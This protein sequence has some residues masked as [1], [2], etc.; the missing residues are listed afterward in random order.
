MANVYSSDGIV[1]IRFDYHSRVCMLDCNYY[2]DGVYVL[3]WSIYNV[4]DTNVMAHKDVMMSRYATM[5]V[6]VSIDKHKRA[7]REYICSSDEDMPCVAGSTPVVIQ[8]G[9]TIAGYALHDART[10]T[11]NQYKGRR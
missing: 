1:S 9:D 10:V 7:H 2:I 4:D 6:L 8:I 5:N 11:I 3:T